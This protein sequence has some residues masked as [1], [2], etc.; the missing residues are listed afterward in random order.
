MPR[1]VFDIETAGNDFDS[2]DKM[3]QDVLT[4]RIKKE[5]KDDAEY[6]IALEKLKNELVFS[7][8][9]SEVVAIGVLDCDK[10][11][12]TV[13]FQAPNKKTEDFEENNIKYKCMTEAEML[14][15]FWMGAENYNEFISFNGRGFDAPFMMIRSA[16]HK[17]RPT[18]NLMYNRYLNSQP[19]NA[20]HVDLYDQLNFYG[21]T[22]KRPGLHMWSRAIGVKS[23]KSEGVKGEDVTRLFREGEYEKIARYNALDLFA[24]HELYKVWR[25]YINT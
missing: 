4:N 1:L 18:K 21:A 25:D 10:N 6:E 5:C 23:P 17:I 3:T 24:T 22:R 9:T 19:T 7:P 16:I 14:E 11:K 15:G 20:K 8:L 13:Y 12:G 2:F